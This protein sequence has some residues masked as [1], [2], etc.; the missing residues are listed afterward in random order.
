MKIASEGWGT[1]SVVFLVA[2]IIQFLVLLIGITV[3]SWIMGVLLT[4][5]VALIVFFFR[6]PER[7]CPADPSIIYSPADGKVVQ[8]ETIDESLYLNQK[9][10]QISI[11]LSPLNVHVNRVPSAGKVE[12]VQ[13]VPGV[14][15]MAWEKEASELNER[16]NF[17]LLHPNGQK[18]LFRQITGFLARRIAYDLEEGDQVEAG[19]RF[20]IMKFGSRMDVVIPENSKILVQIGDTVEASTSVLAQWPSD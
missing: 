6:D 19:Q 12:F 5:L 10:I 9:A 16:A 2:L 20:G 15:L 1:I 3:L 14:N 4:G 11:F 13:Y 8:I 18:L 17:G 7:D